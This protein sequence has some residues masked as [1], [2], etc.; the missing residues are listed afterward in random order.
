MTVQRFLR[1]TEKGNAEGR[2]FVSWSNAGRHLGSLF[3]FPSRN[4]IFIV[5]RP[6]LQPGHLISE[7]INILSVNQLLSCQHA[8]STYSN[9]ID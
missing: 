3:T 7:I 9:F 1:L 2:M 6:Y 4:S 8:K 5:M